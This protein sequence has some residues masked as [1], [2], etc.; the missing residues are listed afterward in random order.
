MTSRESYQTI[1]SIRD[2]EINKQLQGQGC[3]D[4]QIDEEE[5]DDITRTNITTFGSNNKTERRTN[6]Y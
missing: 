6:I 1:E 4:I 2:E 5:T 3:M